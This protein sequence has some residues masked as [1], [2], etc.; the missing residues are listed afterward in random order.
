MS[1]DDVIYYRSMRETTASLRYI[2]AALT[3]L[4]ITSIVII[5]SGWL[6][7]RPLGTLQNSWPPRAQIAP[8]LAEEIIWLAE[9]LPPPPFTL[10]ATAATKD[11]GLDIGYGLALESD[12][13]I[14]TTAVSPLGYAAVQWQTTNA[15]VMLHPWQSWPHVRPLRNELWLDIAA[16]HL[17]IRINRELYA[18]LALMAAPMRVGVYLVNFDS[19]QAAAVQFEQLLLFGN[20]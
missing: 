9:P 1:L 15:P 20:E 6:D 5:L 3:V 10:R 4:T 2:G 14:L 11:S 8:P 18:Q 7:P 12:A 17:T 13:G 16:D 19:E